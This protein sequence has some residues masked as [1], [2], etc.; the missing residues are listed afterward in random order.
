M[1]TEDDAPNILA[2]VWGLEKFRCQK[3]RRKFYIFRDHGSRTAY[4]VYQLFLI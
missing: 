3:Y 4:D 1:N 2:I